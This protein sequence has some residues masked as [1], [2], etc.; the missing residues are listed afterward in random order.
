MKKITLVFRRPFK[1]AYSIEYLF[2]TLHQ[3]IADT[4]INI[5]AYTLPNFSQ[6]LLNRL[7]N[8]FV[9]T[10]IKRGIVHITGDV[11]YAVLGCL[12]S[13]KI[14]TIHDLSFLD[15]TSGI[16][17]VV[18]KWLWIKLPVW[19]ADVVTTVSET[20]RQEVL[21]H[22]K[23]KAHKLQVIPNFV[24]S[25]YQPVD[26]T[27]NSQKP[28]ILQIGTSFNKNIANLA[29][30]LY[31]VPCELVII[32]QPDKEQEALLQKNA[33]SYSTK[34]NLSE[35][36]LHNE[37]LQADILSYASLIEGFGMPILEA[38][39][40]GL[41]VVTSNCSSMPEVAGDGAVFVDPTDA[42]SI[43]M[44]I[45]SLIDNDQLREYVRTKG[46]KNAARFTL[47]DI[48]SQYISLY[49]KVQ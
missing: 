42:N 5:E 23:T 38:Q 9:L 10:R 14:L 2:Q 46:Y 12:F 17:R 3:E 22:V 28:R 26:R 41:P 7:K 27:F 15:R 25:V 21:K 6:G 48:T 4:G 18:Y 30:A 1:N 32:G 44:G 43:R 49:R 37:Y 11:H 19:F 16:S 40:C 20:T 36:E 33:I 39:A 34:S 13:K 31:Q 8:T 45:L 35:T 24:S 47:K 29:A